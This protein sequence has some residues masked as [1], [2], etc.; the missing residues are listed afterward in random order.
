M[1]N[2]IIHF[3]FQ[4]EITK[5]IIPELE[6]NWK[7]THFG[8]MS[9]WDK[10]FDDIIKHKKEN[11]I[12]IPFVSI[13]IARQVSYKT[14]YLHII[15][16]MAFPSLYPMYD[17]RNPLYMH[18]WY[19]YLPKEFLVNDYVYFTTVN[20]VLS[21][22]RVWPNWGKVFIRPVSPWKTFTGFDCKSEEIEFELNCRIQIEKLDRSEM[23]A[24]SMAKD[25]DNVEWRCYYIDGQFVTG[26]PYSWDNIVLPTHLPDSI[27]KLT[28]KAGDYLSYIGSEWVIDIATINGEPKVIEVNAIPTSGWYKGLDTTKLL[29]NLTKIF[30]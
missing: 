3:L 26:V 16:G 19:S 23:I 5:G 14:K 4:E 20:D 28:E 9:G 21:G 6:D 25:L 15:R 18:N 27:K 10:L 7:A 17:M 24:V 1:S 2:K 11:E 22:H 8:Y 30:I 13:D 12:I 29:T